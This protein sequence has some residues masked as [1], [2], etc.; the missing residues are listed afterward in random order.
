[1]AENGLVRRL[2]HLTFHIPLIYL[3]FIDFHYRLADSKNK[4]EE[5]AVLT[6]VTLIVDTVYKIVFPANECMHVYCAHARTRSYPAPRH[7]YVYSGG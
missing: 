2:V 7:T 6:S 4:V 3:L 1:M 5:R